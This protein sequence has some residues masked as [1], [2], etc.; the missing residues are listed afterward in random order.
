MKEKLCYAIEL[1]K[2][3]DYSSDQKRLLAYS[4][5]ILDNEY[6]DKRIY[7]IISKILFD[8]NLPFNDDSLGQTIYNY[9][10]LFDNPK[11]TIKKINICTQYRNLIR[12]QSTL[13][14]ELRHVVT[15]LN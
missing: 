7:D 11:L 3:K 1:L 14:H 12:I 5:I 9:N 15:S 13:L 8:F 6:H 4:S 2:D 10:L